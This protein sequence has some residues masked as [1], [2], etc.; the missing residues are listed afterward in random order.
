[1]TPEQIEHFRQGIIKQEDWKPVER[2]LGEAVCDLARKEALLREAVKI[3]EQIHDS[4][5][6]KG[7]P[8]TDAQFSVLNKIRSELGE[9]K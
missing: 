2:E 5:K 6:R 4:H 8:L 7:L 1:M 3:L 9:Q